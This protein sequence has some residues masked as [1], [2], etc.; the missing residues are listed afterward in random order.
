MQTY[1]HTRATHTKPNKPEVSF[2]G[3]HLPGLG[4]AHYWSYGGRVKFNRII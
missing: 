2:T 1:T 4:H 3:L